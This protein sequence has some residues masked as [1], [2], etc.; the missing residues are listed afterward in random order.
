MENLVGEFFRDNAMKI[1]AGFGQ[2][3]SH[4]GFERDIARLMDEEKRER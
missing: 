4:E 1:G 2:R 3:W